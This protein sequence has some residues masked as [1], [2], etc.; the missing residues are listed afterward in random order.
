MQEIKD[1][2][3]FLKDLR[4]RY[5]QMQNEMNLYL[6]IWRDIRDYIA[7]RT[8][9]FQGELSNNQTRQDLNIINTNPRFA[10][11]TLASGMQSGI[12][13]PLRDWFRLGT[14]D[15][16][17][18]KVGPV[19][20]WLYEVERRMRE[21]MA[22]S[23]LYDRLKSNY[24]IL[25]AYGTS[26]LYIDEDPEDVIR[27]HDFLMGSFMLATNAAGHVD[28]MARTFEMTVKQLIEKFGY[29]NCPSKVQTAK[30]Q[31]Q[32]DQKFQVTHMTQ[33][34]PY[35]VEG[36]ELSE[37]KRF[38][39][40]WLDQVTQDGATNVYK[41]SGYDYNPALG[42]RWDI[43]GED[44]YGTGCGEVSLGDAKQL[45]LLEKRKLQAIEM[46]IMP[47]MLAD[48]SLRNQKTSNL[49]GGKTYVN[50]LING[51]AGYKPAYQI[52]P[53]INEMREEI[54]RVEAKLNEAFFKDLF[55]AVSQLGDQPNITAT[56]I[57]TIREE[58]LMMLGPVLERLNDELLGPIIDIVFNIM[59]KLRH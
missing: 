42:V 26:C 4:T 53:F 10:F 44:T 36:S 6:P 40:I 32:L 13:S 24:G 51:N 7:P 25:G 17:L 30:D 37:K 58:K 41:L 2:E 27:A 59:S 29:E 15:P 31:G 3:N 5:T 43:I 55:L 22:K 8:A 56:Q 57:N 20:E 38:M 18:Q 1:K 33:P 16:E 39:S 46:T 21:V 50:G 11:R 34:N 47:N 49:P 54:A 28:T 19:K 23:N 14:A 45:Q 48:S 12:T 9:R 52:N 35:Y